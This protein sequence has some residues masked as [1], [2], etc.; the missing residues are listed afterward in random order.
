MLCMHTTTGTSPCSSSFTART[1][2]FCS[3]FLATP[4][5]A[6][7]PTSGE[8]FLYYFCASCQKFWSKLGIENTEARQRT[9][10]YRQMANYHGSL[11]PLQGREI[12]EVNFFREDL[13]VTENWGRQEDGDARYAAQLNAWWG[14]GKETSKGRKSRSKGKEVDRGEEK[15]EEPRSRR[16]SVSSTI[17]IWPGPGARKTSEAEIGDQRLVEET[18]MVEGMA[19]L[20]EF[21]MAVEPPLSMPA[22]LVGVGNVHSDEFELVSLE[23]ELPG[24]VN[25]EGSERQE[26]TRPVAPFP[27]P[28]PQRVGSLSLKAGAAEAAR[29]AREDP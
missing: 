2:S 25:G 8:I 5:T 29:G 10:E 4:K 19:E 16:S 23:R 15:V 20:E 27:K 21:G 7:K 24:P 28:M 11:A 12:G 9:L 13:A 14:P 17:T 26:V 1:T 6:C 3:F 22:V 18:G